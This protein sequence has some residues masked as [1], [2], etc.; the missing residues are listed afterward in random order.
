MSA[1]ITQ[2]WYRKAAWLWLLWPLALLFGLVVAI[3]RFMFRSGLLEVYRPNVPVVVVGNIT[4]GGAGKTPLVIALAQALA[5]EGYK[6]GVVSRGYGGQGPFPQ[7]V[8]VNA[9]A[10]QVGD[11]PLLI[12]RRGGAP[13]VVDPDRPRAVK[14]LLEQTS[15]DVI[16]CDDGL[17]HYALA[18]DLEICVVDGRRGLGN[19]LMLP[20]GPLREPRRRLFSVDYVVV[21]GG[22]GN[23]FPGEVAMGLQAGNWV[24]LGRVRTPPAPG[25]RVHALAGI[26]H[27]QR[28]FAQL[29]E[30]GFELVEHAFP[31]HHPYTAADLRFADGLPVV[32]TEKDAVK[33]G[34]ICGD[35]A[36]YVPVAAQL[37]PAF[38]ATLVEDLRRLRLHAA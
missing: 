19:R 33:C 8:D 37:P 32:M 30:A 16:L 22:N 27:P 4:V 23:I 35:N 15:C 20:A 10:E 5:A 14:H 17:Q 36:W 2:A 26:A 21:N 12:A 25:S 38:V 24:P 29:R 7:R 11:E 6:P 1:V 13:V 9:S 18:R 28:F 31:D 34:N 3:R